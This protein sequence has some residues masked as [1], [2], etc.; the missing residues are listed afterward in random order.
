[1]LAVQR[2][3]ITRVHQL[4]QMLQ[5]LATGMTA[6]MHARVDHLIDDSCT[7]SEEVVDRTRHRFLVARHWTGAEDDGV[8]L[9]D[10]D[11]RVVAA[12][13]ST[14]HAGWLALAAR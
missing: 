12:R 14:E 8:V 6:H 4:E 9:L 7:A 13:D 2:H 5:L 11:Q 1:M 10:F 3:Q